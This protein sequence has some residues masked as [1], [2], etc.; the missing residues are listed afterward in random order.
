[1]SIK[2]P[3]YRPTLN[4]NEKKYLNECLD[5]TWISS[6]GRFLDSFEREFAKYIDSPHVTA[7]C[8]GTVALHLAMLSLGIGV[9]DEV[10][11]P[12]L[13][14]VASVNAIR[15]VGATPV[16]V[17]CDRRNWQIN[18]DEIESKITPKTKAIMAVHLYG[19][20]CRMDRLQK[21]TKDHNLWL[22]EDCAEALGT[23]FQG[24]HVGTF[25]D[26]GTF[27][28]FG[29][30]TVTTGEGGM[31]VF[32]DSRLF[33]KA[34]RLKGQGVD[35]NRAYWHDIIGYNFRMTN[36]AASI[37]LAQ[38]ERVDT[39]LEKKRAVAKLYRQ[40]LAHLEIGFQ[41]EEEYSVSSYWMVSILV[42]DKSLRDKLRDFLLKSGVETRPLFYP[43]HE[44]PM[45]KTEECFPVSEDI[46]YRGL[47]LPSF[48]DITEEEISFI[49]R[50]IEVFVCKE[51]SSFSDAVVTHEVC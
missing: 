10:I 34:L 23:Y 51:K 1:M 40:K 44:L 13:T 41:E 48:P 20:A 21:I 25:G 27:S 18:T 35:P 42:S 46:S 39:I 16:F 50:E 38:L 28:F 2:I 29:N 24:Q 33:D 37:G 5:S 6:K 15:Y 11:V 43:I 31:V 17:D 47:N 30:K 3:V 36:L 12:T 19:M 7:V 4:G 22:I 26:V 14:Y 45:Y 9:G 49:C 8:N 32:K